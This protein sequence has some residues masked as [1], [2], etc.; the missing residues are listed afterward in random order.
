MESRWP[1]GTFPAYE[2]GDLG[3]VFRPGVVPTVLPIL[4][5]GRFLRISDSPIAWELRRESEL[6]ASELPYLYI[7]FR[8]LFARA[9]IS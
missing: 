8:Y 4:K 9:E 1:A 3:E 6:L 7:S 5:G 2:G